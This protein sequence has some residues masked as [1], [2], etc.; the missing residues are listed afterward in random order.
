MLVNRSDGVV[1][2][3]YIAG[4]RAWENGSQYSEA[5]GNMRLGKAVRVKRAS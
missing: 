5:L 2:Q 4:Q 3:V 1:E